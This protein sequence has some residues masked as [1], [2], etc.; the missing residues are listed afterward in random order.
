MNNKVDTVV[1]EP[2]ISNKNKMEFFFCKSLMGMGK[3]GGHRLPF[4]LLG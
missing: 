3:R 1:N 4:I 2:E